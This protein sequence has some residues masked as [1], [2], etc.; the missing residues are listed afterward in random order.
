MP[1]GLVRIS[2]QEVLVLY[3]GDPEP[4]K[5]NPEAEEPTNNLVV[6]TL[7]YPRSGAFQVVSAKLMD[8]ES[9][10]P[11]TFKEVGFWAGGL[12]KEEVD[13]ETVLSIDVVDRDKRGWFVR[14]F[15]PLLAAGLVGRL[16]PLAAGVSN[17]FLGG[18]AGALV[19]TTGEA[20]RGGDK[21][22][23]QTVIGETGEVELR[24]AG[25]E[26][27]WS[28]FGKALATQELREADGRNSGNRLVLEMGLS[29]PRLLYRTSGPDATIEREVEPRA[30]NGRVVVEIQRSDL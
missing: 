28:P 27:A 17:A 19:E 2:L 11:K 6:A 23:R 16:S 5:R 29:A 22:Y 21:D 13:G 4:T 20:I 26:I 18:I 3:N 10:K 9:K 1:R 7:K 15:R 8:L 24:I 25:T 30:S 14:A 12:F